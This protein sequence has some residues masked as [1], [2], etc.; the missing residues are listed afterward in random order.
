MT[1]KNP[2]ELLID[3]CDEKIKFHKKMQKIALV[4]GVSSFV[5]G[6]G[7]FSFYNSGSKL[8][9]PDEKIKIEEINRNLAYL[10]M[11]E[12]QN[13]EI[14]YPALKSNHAEFDELYK[15]LLDNRKTF[16]ESHSKLENSLI[17]NREILRKSPTYVSY[18]NE[19][20]KNDKPNLWI[21][22]ISTGLLFLGLGLSAYSYSQEIE[23]RR[24]RS[25]LL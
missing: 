16:L 13:N 23:Y 21:I 20:H 18:Q 10:N 15:T 11:V 25:M 24:Q 6:M 19:I 5:F 1:D 12:K 17:K 7:V 14:K 4:S 8:A 9:I 2:I 22:G 3:K